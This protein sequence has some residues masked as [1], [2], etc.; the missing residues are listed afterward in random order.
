MRS[1]PRR[2]LEALGEMTPKEQRQLLQ[3]ALSRTV[4][5][6]EKLVRLD[7]LEQVAPRLKKE[8]PKKVIGYL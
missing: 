2:V 4:L 5:L 7:H 8:P 1:S 3:Q 6:G